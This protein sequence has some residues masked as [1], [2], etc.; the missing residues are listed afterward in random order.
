MDLVEL[1]KKKVSGGVRLEPEALRKSKPLRNPGVSFEV[2]EDGTA[3][4]LAPLETQGM[5]VAGLL[6]R[7]MKA[8][9]HKKIE[10][11]PIGAYVWELCD[12]ST[13]FES[14]SK[15]LRDRY[16]MNRLEA[17]AALMEFLQLLSRRRLI[18][19]LVANKK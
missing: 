11:E 16:K 8:P 12:G 1:V 19:L 10:L 17:D 14:I 15:K 18:T 9:S 7:W 6:A 13:T 5:G 3:L 4:L 2:A